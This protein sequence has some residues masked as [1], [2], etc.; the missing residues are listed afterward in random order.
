MGDASFRA[1]VT[2]D[3]GD[4]LE[5]QAVLLDED[6]RAAL[7]FLKER[8]APRVPARGTAACDSSRL[9]PFLWKTKAGD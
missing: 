3:G 2:L 8:V 5:L 4:L 9:N 7:A 6:E 1:V